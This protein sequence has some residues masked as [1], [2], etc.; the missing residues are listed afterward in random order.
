[1]RTKL[2]IIILLT[3]LTG[4]MSCK[5]ETV[6]EGVRDPEVIKTYHNS[7]SATAKMD[8]VAS[9]HFITRQK[10]VEIYELTSLYSSSKGDTLMEGILYPQIQTYFPE[11]DTMSIRNLIMELDSLKVH[12]V[13]IKNMELEEKDSLQ[14]DSVWTVNF[15]VRYFSKDKKL[16]TSESKKAAY[17][18]KKE[19]RKFKHEFVFFFTELGDHSFVNDT[20]SSGVTQ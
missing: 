16:I 17:V 2:W 18:L 7:S 11:A 19:P 4:L 5:K 9:V 12:Y 1:M 15:D 6:F 14:P 20:I 13:E 8:S 3:G 10:L